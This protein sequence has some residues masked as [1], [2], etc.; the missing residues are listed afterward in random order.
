MIRLIIRRD[1]VWIG[2]TVVIA[3]RALGLLLT[4]S[5]ERTTICVLQP[6]PKVVAGSIAIRLAQIS[7]IGCLARRLRICGLLLEVYETTRQ[8]MAVGMGVYFEV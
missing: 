1:V 2:S 7:C 6:T 5:S 8:K 3:L 4:E